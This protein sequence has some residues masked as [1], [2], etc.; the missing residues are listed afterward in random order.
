MVRAVVA[1]SV[2]ATIMA[3]PMAAG[4]SSPPNL[5]AVKL[6]QVDGYAGYNDIWGYVAPDGREYACVGLTNGVSIVNCTDPL[7]PFEVG[8]FPGTFCTW[9]DLKTYNEYLYVVNDCSAGIEVIDM[10]DPDHPLLV[11]VFGLGQVSHA[12]NVAID[13]ETGILY[14]VGTQNGMHVYDLDVNPLNPPQISVWGPNYVHDIS[15]QDGVGH[16]ALIYDGVYRT[17]DVTDPAHITTIGLTQSGANFA[18]S[19]WPTAD[20]NVVVVADEK[21]TDRHLAFFDVSN[22]AQPVKL[23]QFVEDAQSIP[24]NP[25]IRGNVCHVS[26][27]TEGYIAIDISD[28]SNPV[29]VGR[30][31]TQPNTESGGITGFNGAWGCYPFQPSGVIY[32]SDRQ[33][34]LFVVNFNECSVD[35]PAQPQPQVCKVWPPVVSALSSPR[36]RII[37][38]GAGFLGATAVTVGSKVLG[39]TEFTRIGDQVIHF[40]MPLVSA[41]GNNAITV[42]NASGTSLPVQVQ[43]TPP[44][45]PLLDTGE[46]VQAVG[47]SFLVAVG[48]QPGDLFYP[49]ASLSNVPS[50]APGTVAFGIGNNFAN[51]LWLQGMVANG[52]GVGGFPVVVPASAL[53]LKVFWQV[54]VVNPQQGLPASVTGVTSTTV[55]AAN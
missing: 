25:Y 43:V 51:L 48:S 39:P 16:A 53:G 10:S 20:N 30:Y 1:L 44:V 52:A 46:P 8:S 38:T 28:P 24:H 35:L 42:T 6:A 47:A 54:A 5:N 23:S 12:H 32:V 17:L 55:V 22:P 36:Q 11:S 21:A 29:K 50:I 45:G 15:I 49:V 41:T 14:A 18:H 31:D 4:Q 27:Y 13:V 19:T 40:R 2:L 7:A 3:G 26:W 9:R 33:R 37:L 34:G